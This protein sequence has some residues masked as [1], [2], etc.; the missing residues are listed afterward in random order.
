MIR[1]KEQRR[2]NKLMKKRMRI[3]ERG[4]RLQEKQIVYEF[5]EKI[6]PELVGLILSYLGARDLEIFNVSHCFLLDLNHFL[7]YNLDKLN[8]KLF[9]KKS[10]DKTIFFGLK[11]EDDEDG[12]NDGDEDDEDDGNETN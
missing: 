12:E 9:R 6:C 5:E 8:R 10:L 7:D 2:Q 3:L 4:I 1:R 11:I